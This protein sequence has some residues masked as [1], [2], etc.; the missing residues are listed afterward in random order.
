MASQLN[1][2]TRLLSVLAIG[3]L[4]LAGCSSEKKGET[5][6]DFAARVGSRASA[7]SAEPAQAAVET[8][9]VIAA[10]PAG[11]DVTTLEKLGNIAGV[12]L[13]PRAG[14]CT[15]SSGG[16]EMLTSAAPADITR[17]GRGV[18]RA[19]GTL[20]QLAST[21]G[22]PALRSGTRFSGEGVT[23]DVNAAGQASSIIVTDGVGRSKSYTGS[24][25][26]A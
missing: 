5:A 3:T 9:A 16:V 20:Y 12:D 24:W 17:A 6:D 2:Q 22:L 21:G 15:F 1:R 4:M 14:G 10:P 7:T 11:V 23:V 8:T 13:G 26:C 25:V 18:I 19:G